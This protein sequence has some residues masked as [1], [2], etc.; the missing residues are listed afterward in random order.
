MSGQT[1]RPTQGSTAGEGDSG[2]APTRSCS[3]AIESEHDDSSSVDDV[4][5]NMLSGPGLSRRLT[6]R[7][8]INKRGALRRS[9]R[10]RRPTGSGAQ[11]IPVSHLDRNGSAVSLRCRLSLLLHQLRQPSSQSSR[12]GL[13]STILCPSGIVVLS[14][15]ARLP[16]RPDWSPQV[17]NPRP[18]HMLHA[19][20]LLGASE[21]H[22]RTRFGRV[23]LVKIKCT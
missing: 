15:A 7:D 20:E 23:K 1:A 5:F 14:A 6:A 19:R 9:R 12:R 13:P 8:S 18:E 17:A 21:S 4:S 22:F 11:W 16:K 10:C 3:D 2:A